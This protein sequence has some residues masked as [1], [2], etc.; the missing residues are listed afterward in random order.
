[1]IFN[2][3]NSVFNTIIIYILFLLLIITNKP[4]F[5]YDRKRRKFKNFGSSKGETLLSLPIFSILLAIIIYVIFAYIE[6]F[7]RLQDEYYSIIKEN[8]STTK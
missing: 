3:Y 2:P 8:K 4:K 1:M 5:L 7:C 6:R